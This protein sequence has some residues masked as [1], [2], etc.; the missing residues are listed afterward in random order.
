MITQ[1]QIEKAKEFLKKRLSAELSMKVHLEEEMEE[2][3]KEI[4]EVALKYKVSPKNFKFSSIPEMEKEVDEIVK[5]LRRLIYNYIDLLS[6]YTHKEDR[7]EIVE[8][9]NSLFH[10]KT[11]K[12]RISI[13]CNRYKY[14]I[15]AAIV[16]GL[17]LGKSDKNI[18]S[19]ITTNMSAPYNNPD[20]KSVSKM[21]VSSQ[22]RLRSG[23]ISY[24][25]GESNSSYNSMLK[26]SRN[27]IADSWMWWQYVDAKRDGAIGFYQYRGSSF[28]CSLCDSEVGYHS[29][30][31]DYGFPHPYC[32][33]FRVYVY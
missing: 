33:C 8:H 10:G 1:K 17:I 14:E 29:I 7:E 5:K 26:L 30:E 25:P 9:M 32:K 24:G 18:L 12:E 16:S 15:E 19:S 27:T 11:L 21:G 20:L 3:A 28:P 31:S 23:G 22:V 4:I 13:Y 6:C 2:A